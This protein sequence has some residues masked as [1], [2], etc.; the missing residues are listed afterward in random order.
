MASPKKTIPAKQRFW[1]NRPWFWYD[2][3]F[4]VTANSPKKRKQTYKIDYMNASL[5]NVIINTY[6]YDLNPVIT[7]LESFILNLSSISRHWLFLDRELDS[8]N[9]IDG[10]MLLL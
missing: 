4:V 6:I 8:L 2:V 1:I 9:N 10:K 3:M 7:H 5:F